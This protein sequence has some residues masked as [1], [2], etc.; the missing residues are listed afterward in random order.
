M[1]GRAGRRG[2]D[3]SGNVYIICCEPLGKNKIKKIK[4]LLK[5]EGNELESKFR[6]SYRIILSFYHRNLKNINDFF[7]ESFHENHNTEIKPEKLK[8]IEQIKDGV[9]KINKTL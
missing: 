6:L 5:G 8:E 3:S 2:I 4:E 7:Q 1:C 9:E